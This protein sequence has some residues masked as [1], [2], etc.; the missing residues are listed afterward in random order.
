MSKQ[1]AVG[2][3]PYSGWLNENATNQ[4]ALTGGAWVVEVSTTSVSVP[5]TGVSSTA[6][7]GTLSVQTGTNITITGV[8]STTG[9]GSLATKIDTAITGV[10]SDGAV[11]ALSAGTETNVAL[12]GVSA[13]A[14]IGVLTPGIPLTG[15]AATG[16]VGTVAIRRDAAL[17]LTG[18]ASLTDVGLVDLDIDGNLF[19]NIFGV[20]ST[21]ATGTL[22]PAH[23]PS[24]LTGVQSTAGIGQPLVRVTTNLADILLTG[25]E[26]DTAVGSFPAVVGAVID[27]VQG[28]GQT[29]NLIAFPSTGGL[30][31][32]DLSCE[33]FAVATEDDQVTLRW[34]DTDGYSWS[35]SVR[36]SI[37]AT[38]Q[39]L[40]NPQWRRLGMSRRGRV[41]EIS[42]SCDQPT[43]LQGATVMLEDAST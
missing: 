7:A 39:Y 32:T 3:F 43:A 29:G 15:V 21:P 12:T 18:V 26:S 34:S 6:A 30:S 16:A 38:G 24:P 20:A 40:T 14:A 33:V 36:R 4:V 13:T 2:G 8:S 17:T 41:F 31:L 5:L 10:E 22:G 42:W 11:G 37:G 23:S 27:G 1:V 35:D 19:L 9:I 25:V 28:T